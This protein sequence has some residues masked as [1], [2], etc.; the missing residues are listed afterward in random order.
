MELVAEPDAASR[1]LDAICGGD[2][3][4]V[5]RLIEY[6]SLECLWP[7][8]LFPRLWSL[9]FDYFLYRRKKP[10]LAL[11]CSIILSLVLP[12]ILVNSGFMLRNKFIEMNYLSR[13]C[14]DYQG[15]ACGSPSMHIHCVSVDHLASGGM[16]TF[17]YLFFPM[18]QLISL[19]CLILLRMSKLIAEVWDCQPS[20]GNAWRFF[21]RMLPG[22]SGSELNATL[23]STETDS[24]A[25]D[26][27]PV[28]PDPLV[29]HVTAPEYQI[30]QGAPT[31]QRRE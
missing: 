24:H 3:N 25:G 22:R 13:L 20:L 26:F 4:Y 10:L 31:L 5:A 7:G 14:I 15:N 17:A 2:P 21:S 28:E 23:L 29:I 27:T 11:A 6:L 16:Q 8:A 12:A 30:D 9:A 1:A 18:M 19:A